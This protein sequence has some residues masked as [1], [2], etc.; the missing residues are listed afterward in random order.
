MSSCLLVV[1]DWVMTL[2]SGSSI[3]DEISPLLRFLGFSMSGGGAIEVVEK[4]ISA[5]QQLAKGN[6]YSL[7]NLTFIFLRLHC[8]KGILLKELLPRFF[9]GSH[10]ELHCH[11]VGGVVVRDET[12]RL[13][14]ISA[15]DETG[16]RRNEGGRGLR[17]N[18]LS[19]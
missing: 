8:P 5:Q 1:F 11:D 19:P 10:C 13:I 4:F 7:E 6:L 12:Y 2:S 18:D 16:L 17:K 9:L 14:Y 3:I 15:L